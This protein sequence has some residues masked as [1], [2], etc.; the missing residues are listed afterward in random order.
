MLKKFFGDRYFYRRLFAL[1]V[2]IMIQNGIT[3]F[4]NMLDNIMIGRV[5]TVQMNGVAVANQL[6][7]VFNLCIFGAV[8]GAGIFGA[9]FYG[10]GDHKG[11]RDTF[12][13]KLIFCCLLTLVGIGLFYFAGDGLIGLYLQGEGS[14]ADAA[15]S[16][17]F[18]KGY[19]L[20][21]L[22]GLLPYTLVQCY[23]STLREIGRPMVP[24]TAG[25]IAVL[26]NLVLNYV[27][28]FGHFG[29][30]AL[31]VNGAAIAT[32]ISRFTELLV[33]AFWTHFH[34]HKN[35]FI[36]GA[37][38]SL[39]VPK[40]LVGRIVVKGLPLMLNEALWAAGIATV[41]QCY[42]VRGL[43]VVGAQNIAQ[44]FWNVFSIA[45][46]A[47]GVANGIILG[48]MLGA[49]DHRG[50]KDAATKLITFS[51]LVSIGV[52]ALY[53]LVAIWI[54]MAYNTT[55][56]IRHLATLLMQITALAMPLDAFS[57]ATYFTLRSGGKT[58]ITFL[59]D[60]GFVWAIHVPL[61]FVLSRYTA[62]PILGLY[63]LIQFS[64]I[65]K[66]VLGFVFVKKG[67]WLQ[68]IVEEG[69]SV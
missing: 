26:V 55:Y 41:N 66:V 46:M 24:M 37:Y 60:S 11:L 57:H 54:P 48:Q 50:A 56:E 68:N 53:A 30:P 64:N 1:A 62:M 3:N 16:L 10:K 7:F 15:A 20:I 42:S 40:K 63:A 4:V 51:V 28:I 2:P 18:G 29:A 31:G 27:L 34:A 6:F 39:R 47:V 61:A 5:G 21:M 43:N 65:I 23:S 19:L 59:F 8:S 22:V 14:A 17:G 67:I 69:E 9:Q 25:I 12:R 33:V 58:F 36:I 45:F 49:R 13:F 35:P 44:T 38:R 32:V 52:G